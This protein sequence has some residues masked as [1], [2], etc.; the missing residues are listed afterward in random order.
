MPFWWDTPQSWLFGLSS[1]LMLS[2][3]FQVP[4]LETWTCVDATRRQDFDV[5]FTLVRELSKTIGILLRFLTHWTDS[6]H[7]HHFFY[8]LLFFVL[9]TCPRCSPKMCPSRDCRVWTW[10]KSA[11][12]MRA[13]GHRCFSTHQENCEDAIPVM[14]WCNHTTIT[15]H[16]IGP[17]IGFTSV[18]LCW[19]IVRI[20]MRGLTP[21]TAAS[22]LVAQG[23]W[24]GA[25]HPV[26]ECKRVRTDEFIG[27][28]TVHFF[29]L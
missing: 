18:I 21:V 29:M 23:F 22:N 20:C 11:Q 14:M 15:L 7:I 4:G 27:T 24:R 6:I 17:L 25:Q 12:S 26:R 10:S 8:P 19:N 28:S 13:F 16:H 3:C 5:S 1:Y 2:T 9:N